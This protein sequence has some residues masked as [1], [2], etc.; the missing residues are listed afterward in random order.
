MTP[1]TVLG[2]PGAE[3]P[4]VVS[5]W[6][7]TGVFGNRT[8]PELAQHV[9]CH[10]CPVFSAAGRQ[11]LNRPLPA[12]YRVERTRQF[13]LE[14]EAPEAGGIS[15]VLFRVCA[16]WLA[17]PTHL[18]QEV[19]EARPI[20]SLPHRRAGPVLGL[21]NVRGELLMCVSLAHLLSMESIPSLEEL[22]RSTHQ[23]LVVHWEGMRIAFPVTD[24]QGPHRFPMQVLRS[25]PATLASSNPGCTQHI[26]SWQNRA[27]GMLDPELLFAAV[28]R[29]LA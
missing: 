1:E 13:A 19:T 28:N 14:K 27:V 16:E 17:L 18:F 24:V 20:H 7:Q 11:L 3:M 21:A 6:N 26:L 29:G 5:C 4:E 8:C 12:G 2:A 23:L 22:R 10:H 15:A 25:L 9:H